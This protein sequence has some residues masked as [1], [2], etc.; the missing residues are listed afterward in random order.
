MCGR[1]IENLN[2]VLKS[3]NIL[4]KLS[5]PAIILFILTPTLFV[6]AQEAP[7]VVHAFVALCDNKHQGIVP[8]P[9]ILGNDDDP[10]NNLYWGAMYG[11]K[12]FFK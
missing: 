8:V 1:L 6:S 9:A 2:E 7:R 11:V 5:V 12:T 10:K 3:M 4:R